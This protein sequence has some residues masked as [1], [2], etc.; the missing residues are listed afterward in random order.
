MRKAHG[1]F[2]SAAGIAQLQSAG[3][4]MFDPN[5]AYT[6]EFH[7]LSWNTWVIGIGICHFSH[8]TIPFPDW[9]CRVRGAQVPLA[10]VIST[11]LIYVSSG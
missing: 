8:F 11:H 3:P 2:D 9:D 1:I 10:P 4:E 7:P 6:L 5:K